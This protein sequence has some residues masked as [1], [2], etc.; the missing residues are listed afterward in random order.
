MSTAEI[1]FSVGE[2]AQDRKQEARKILWAFLAALVI[3][4]IIGFLLA[5]LSAVQS[6]PLPEEDKPVEL[7][8]VD[9]PV[10]PTKPKNAQFIETDE[11]KASTEAPEEKTFQSN[12]N[13]IGASEAAPSGDMPLPSQDGREDLNTLDLQNQSYTLANRGTAAQPAAAQPSVAPQ[14]TAPP[15][16][17]AA[18]SQA[19]TSAPTAPPDQL[20][21]L[22]ARPSPAAEAPTATP[23]PEAQPTPQ[24]Q[25]PSSAY[26]PEQQK[27]RISGNIS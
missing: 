27:T 26:R 22:T 18:P 14:A 15:E 7:T 21:M 19:P 2:L 17:S 25:E 10:A 5:I 6:I 11:S 13:S 20:A 24:P 12:A 1:T 4:V 3:H 23:A 8:I 9:M 16:P